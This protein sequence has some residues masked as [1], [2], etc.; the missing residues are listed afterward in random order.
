MTA[1]VSAR[2]EASRRT[3]ATRARLR[4]RTRG[5]RPHASP[6]RPRA[7]KNASRVVRRPGCRRA[8]RSM[9]TT[10]CLAEWMPPARMRV[11]TVVV[12]TGAARAR[13]AAGSTRAVQRLQSAGA[14]ARRGRRRHASVAQPPSAAT[15]LAALPAPPGTISVESYS[16]MRTGASRE[17]RATR[18]YTNS[19]ATTSPINGDAAAR[20]RVDQREDAAQNPPNGLHQIVEDSI[21]PRRRRAASP[22]RARHG[23][24]RTSTVRVPAPC[25]HSDVE[26]AGRRPSPNG[27]DRCDSSRQAC[28]IIPDAGLRH[29]HCCRSSGDRPRPGGGDRSNTRSIARPARGQPGVDRRVDRAAGTA[30]R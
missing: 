19:S 3:P 20:Q 1:P 9:R 23:P 7:R 14:R 17:T 22:P 21:G 26:A 25:P 13:A 10:C 6:P 12:L 5:R 15:L 24:V 30:R 4:S 2:R 29:A 28:S 27:S 8:T 16:R 18:P 11:L